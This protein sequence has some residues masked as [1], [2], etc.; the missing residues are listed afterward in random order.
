MQAQIEK[1]IYEKS[2]EV[3]VKHH[4]EMIVDQEL[5]DQI[6]ALGAKSAKEAKAI[7]RKELMDAHPDRFIDH[8]K[9][10][11]EKVKSHKGSPKIASLGS[12]SDQKLFK[13]DFESIKERIH[14]AKSRQE[15]I[16]KRK[17]DNL[18]SHEGSRHRPQKHSI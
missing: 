3:N 11:A 2:K 12:S 9:A 15:R 18:V 16:D 14:T 6:I 8:E 5:A 13:D 10:P 4:T 17:Q 1:E 7:L